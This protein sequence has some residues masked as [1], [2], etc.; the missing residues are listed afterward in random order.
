MYKS[1]KKISKINHI[2]SRKSKRLSDEIIKPRAKSDNS[3]APALNYVGNKIRVTFDGS[4]LRQNK[5]TYTHGTIVN[6][7]TVY[8]FSSNL[9]NLD[10]ALEN[11]LFGVVKITTNADIDKYKYSGYDI[12]FD[13][14]GTFL[15][16]S[17]KFGQNVIILVLV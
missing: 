2:S 17:G 3:L 11:Y 8:E 12:R 7:Y 6:I 16:P 14:L 13:S 1:F 15:F 4:C 5:I 10:F 9:N